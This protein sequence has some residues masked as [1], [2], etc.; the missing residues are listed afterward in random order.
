MAVTTTTSRIPYTGDGSSTVFPVPFYFLVDTDIL[1]YSGESLLTSGYSVIGAGDEEGGS[2]KFDTAPAPGV[3]LTILRAPDMLQQTRLPPNDPFPSGSVEKMS[4][5]LTMI[6]QR[7][8]DQISRALVLADFDVDGSGAYRAN[9]NRI[10]DVGDPVNSQDAVNLRT[11]QT[12]VA[13]LVST[14]GGDIVLAMLANNAD[15]TLGA[16]LIGFDGDTLADFFLS[17]NNRVVDSIAALR[18]ISK[19]TYTR[20][21]VTGYYAAG[22]GGGGPYYY[23]STDTTS[24][25][26]GGTILVAADGGRWKLQYTSSVSVKQFGAK[27]DGTTD[28]TNALSAAVTWAKANGHP[29]LTIPSGIIRV[30]TIDMRGY[31]GGFLGDGINSTTIK[32]NSAVT[33]FINLNETADVNPSAF[34]LSGLTIDGNSQVTNGINARY[35]HG[36]LMENLQVINCTNGVVEKD[37]YLSRHHNCRSRACAT[38]WTL[39]GSNHSSTFVGCTFDQNTTMQLLIQ[40]NG[41]A[42]DGNSGLAFLGCDIEFGS[43]GTAAGCSI[44]ATDV[45]FDGCYIGENISTSIVSIYAGVLNINGG[46]LFFG[47]TTSSY[48]IVVAGSSARV[49]VR[50]T[51]IAGQLNPGIQYLAYQSGAGSVGFFD[52]NYNGVVSGSPT[53]TGDPLSYGPQGT[54]YAPRL[55]KQWTGEGNNVTF[56]T[57]VSGNQQ[58]WTVLT[59]PGP[60]PLLGAR[61]ALSGNAGWRDGETLYLIIVYQSSKPINVTLSGGAFGIAPTKTIQGSFPATSGAFVT[62]IGLQTNADNAAYT[63]I[64]VIQQSS[65]VNDSLTISEVFLADSRMLNKMGGQ[66]GNL[67]KC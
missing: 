41:T 60:T 58:S 47:Y 56:S 30:S 63:T 29:C 45:S 35:R 10:Q 50:N 32:A 39:V 57:S 27:V 54:V 61:A 4:D 64:E 62:G 3:Q 31:Y 6:V 12:A 67:Y 22:D 66:M 8:S 17:K 53:M 11:M 7:N 42:A 55:G 18:T 33:D 9:Q 23:D 65:G 37:T 34:L 5:K 13:D 43:G 44:T 15:S 25:D 59:A 40:S 1:V 36:Y 16:A 19:T 38:G 24:T 46:T 48:G 20:A 21:F 14:G 51:S 52:C 2:V 26:N 49:N 28:D